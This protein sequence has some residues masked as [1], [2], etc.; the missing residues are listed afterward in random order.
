MA[1][2]RRRCRVGQSLMVVL[3]LLLVM[4]SVL[5][6]TLDFGFV[7]LSRRTMQA[8]VNTASLEGARDIGEEGRE[9]ARILMRNVYDDDLDPRQN[10]TTLGA[11]PE[12]SL[13]QRDTNDRT[14]LGTGEGAQQL[15]SDR[16]QYIYR[17]DPEL[18]LANDGSGDFVI[19]EYQSPSEYPSDHQENGSY[20]RND[21][22]LDSTGSAFLSRLRR[23][24]ARSGVANPLDRIAGVSSSG[25]GSPLLLGHLS[26]FIH[27]PSGS[28]DIRRD[29]VAIRAT[30][31]ADRK[32]IVFIGDGEG[33]T[34]YSAISFAYWPDL[35]QWYEIATPA[36]ALGETVQLVDQDPS[37]P[38]I[39]P[40]DIG[41]IPR[42]GY[43]AVIWEDLGSHYVV[44]FRLL[45]SGEDRIPNGSPRLQ[46]AWPTLEALSA[47]SRDSILEKH[48]EYSGISE[49]EMS[50]LPAQVRSMN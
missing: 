5:A 38:D 23:T 15:L 22:I 46:D 2:D 9:N 25:L 28:Y 21:F 6:L 41:E 44:G 17:P 20:E 12:Q 32:P 37:D 30:A 33:E 47:E 36:H 11:G 16:Y 43:A 7:L 4:V 48:G 26:F 24:P 34:F 14:V 49:I 29:G 42:P 39:D 31:I 27:Q 40:V 8:G 1:L 13:V 50:R 10:F 45:K 3:L 18:N 19:G 35:N